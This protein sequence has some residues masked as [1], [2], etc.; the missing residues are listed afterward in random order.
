V[1]SGEAF[2]LV[3]GINADLRSLRIDC[4]LLV[5]IFV[6]AVFLD[7]FGLEQRGQLTFT[8]WNCRNIK[9]LQLACAE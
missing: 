5:A 1:D 8:P 4:S 7:I 6:L 3:D 2:G 9:D